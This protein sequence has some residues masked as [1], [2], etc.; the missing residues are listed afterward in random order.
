MRST[1]NTALRLTS[2]MVTTSLSMLIL[3]S[4]A[5]AQDAQTINPADEDV[6]VA[7][8]TIQHTL[9]RSLAVKRNTTVVSDA[10]VGAEIGDLPD[11]S[12]AESL[13]RITEVTSDR[14]QVQGLAGYSDHEDRVVDGQ[15]ISARITG[16]YTDQ[17]ETGTGDIGIAFGG[18]IRRDTAAED[19]Y[20]SSSRARARL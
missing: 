1:K 10:L 7:T 3:T 15:P 12:I 4:G 14:L 5:Y 13:E 17:F 8:G 20:S 16:S 18:Q 6:V 2:L 19:I 11:L 9:E